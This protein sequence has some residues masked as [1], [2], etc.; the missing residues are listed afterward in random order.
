M[1]LDGQPL[2]EATTSPP[3]PET[4]EP[5][6]TPPVNRLRSIEDPR[7]PSRHDRPEEVNLLHMVNY[8]AIACEDMLRAHG[9]GCDCD[10]CGAA[11]GLRYNLDVALA[12]LD[13]NL[14][15]GIGDI[16]DCPCC[17]QL[18]DDDEPEAT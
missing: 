12:A 5:V 16:T 17:G 8:T 7:M 14:H 15:T 2:F 18:W 3:E 13:S 10:L 9:E 1:F 6:S 4:I 11:C